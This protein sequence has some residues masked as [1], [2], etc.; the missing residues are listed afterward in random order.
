MKDLSTYLVVLLCLSVSTLWA[1]NEIPRIT[2]KDS[3]V[4]S[5]W[6]LGLGYNI[7]DDSGDAFGNL[8]NIQEQWNTT[9]LPNRIAVGRY[10]KN[11]IGLE[12]IGGYNKY[13][14]GKR[15]EGRI[16]TEQIDYFS[17]DTR[18]SY[19]LNRIFGGTSWFDP[20]IGAGFG[21]TDANNTG[22]TTY[23]AVVGF[24]I[25]ITDQWGIDLN[26]S[27][28]WRTADSGTNHIQHAAG[29]VYQFGIEKGLSRRGLEKLATIKGIESERQRLADSTAMAERKAEESAALAKRLAKEK[30][31]IRLAQEAQAKTDAENKI[32]TDL[33]NK[34]K[35]VGYANFDLNSSYLNSESHAVLDK[36][37]KVLTEH[38][39]LHL[40]VSSHTDSRGKSSYN[41]WLSDRRVK[42]TIDYLIAK[43]IDETRL[44]SASFGEENLLNECD[45]NTYC[46]EEKH[47]I[48]RRSEFKIIKFN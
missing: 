3:I 37:V 14:I 40:E 33:E 45:D 11:G 47:R 10:F 15:I 36:L 34:I 28:K 24:R 35:N 29:V 5:S 17:I 31:A 43:G 9:A 38:T 21:Y 41:K 6:N 22:T 25:W 7:V 44:K 16:N 27:G 30:E 1:Q 13:Q 18:V 46:P 42:R 48:N 2:S 12:A 26:S 20:F 39:G 23:N 8:F 19:D 32:K 4:K